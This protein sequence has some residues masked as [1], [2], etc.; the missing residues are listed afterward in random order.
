[1]LDPADALTKEDND[2]AHCC[3]L[4]DP[5]VTSREHFTEENQ[6]SNE[7]APAQEQ[8][9]ELVFSRSEPVLPRF[10]IRM[11]DKVLVSRFFLEL[12]HDAIRVHLSGWVH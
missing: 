7:E 6:A 2:V 12:K 9:S 4:R 11:I 3:G 5:M 1:M 10:R 8:P